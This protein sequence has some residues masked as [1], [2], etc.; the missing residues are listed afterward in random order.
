MGSPYS[1]VNLNE[2]SEMTIMQSPQGKLLNYGTVRL[3]KL[4]YS[5]FDVSGI[6]LPIIARKAISDA[7]LKINARI[8]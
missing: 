7:V 3:I 2:V 6:N 8:V 5:V 4:D 1:D